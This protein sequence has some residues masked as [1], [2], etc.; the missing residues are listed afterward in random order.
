MVETVLASSA[1]REE[2]AVSI[3]SAPASAGQGR[4]LAARHPARRPKHK[5]N[6]WF[7]RSRAKTKTESH[8]GAPWD[9][10][11]ADNAHPESE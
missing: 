9:G 7:L 8:R 3:D 4:I 11:A 6:T 10:L 2:R 5:V 1:S